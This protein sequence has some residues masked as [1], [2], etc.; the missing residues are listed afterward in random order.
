MIPLVIHNADILD[1]AGARQT[2]TYQGATE[3]HIHAAISSSSSAFPAWSRTAPSYRRD[4]LRNVA[5]LIHERSAALCE[6]MYNE[7]HTPPDW[8]QGN[9]TSAIELLEE[10]AGLISEVV[11][12]SLPVTKGDSVAMVVKEPVGVVLAIAPW[13]APLFLG[14]RAIVAALAAGNTVLF[15]VCPSSPPL[16][17]H[18]HTR[19]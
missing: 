9:V 15:K 10:T 19:I 16:F 2:T 11:R 3:S 8:A 13:N 12:G 1:P 5:R 17:N 14:F 7:T 4:L 18:V 6:E